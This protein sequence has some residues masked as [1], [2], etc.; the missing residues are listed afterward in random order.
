[1]DGRTGRT[2]IPGEVVAEG[3][4]DKMLEVV[5]GAPDPAAS[6]AFLLVVS[7]A[8]PGRLHV[9]DRPEVII[10]RSRYADIS[11]SERALSQQ[12]CKLVRHGEFHR[13][14]DLGSTNGTFVNNVRVQQAELKPGDSVRTGET[15]FTYMSG[16]ADAPAP[17]PNPGAPVH[18]QVHGQHPQ[19]QAQVHPQVHAPAVSAMPNLQGVPDAPS[20][21]ALAAYAPPGPQHPGYAPLARRG[22]PHGGEMIPAGYA[23]MPQVLA[24]PAATEE[25]ADLL[26]W[27]LKGIDF[28]RRYWL[29]IILL[30]LAGGALGGAS[31]KFKK[32]PARAE[33]ELSLIPMG[34]DNPV[35]GAR[36]MNFE[37]FRDAQNNF[38]RPALIHET[39]KEL[40]ETEISEQT[41]RGVV[42][43]LEF[44]KAGQFIYK[45]SFTSSTPEGAVKYL[46][47]HLR[48]YKE[49][50]IEK[51][52]RVLVVEATTLEE[53]LAETEEQLSAT[54]EALLAFKQENL[55]GLPEQ[56]SDLYR[57]L[58][59]L[60]TRKT[61]MSAEVAKAQNELALSRKQLK[62]E[63]PLIE[64]R[65]QESIPFATGIADLKK[66]IA[67][68][69]SEGKGEQHPMVGRAKEE[70]AALEALRD[71][72]IAHGTTKIVKSR[73]P[74]YKSYR[75]AVDE[76]ETNYE[77]TM[78]DLGAVTKDLVKTEELVQKLPRLQA[79]YSELV[80]SYDITEKTHA[81]LFSNLKS[82]RVRLEL[83]RAQAA[84]R[85]D[86]I[87]R[88]NVRPVS[89]I[90]TILI[91]SGMGLFGGLIFGIGLGVLRDLRRIVGA[92]LAARRT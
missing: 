90:F 26:T 58:I 73:N 60:G 11:I 69:R 80:R 79:E 13:L 3:G 35:E 18:P 74:V 91:R 36:R 53:Q 43:G 75:H 83:E 15:L 29:S 67:L 56:S 48:L 76:A 77:N 23:G 47:V 7:G 25:P 33:F 70:L 14:F 16:S 84:A 66:K 86:I 32:P 49:S 9:I 20:V 64:A 5:A 19:G 81:Q 78:A 27:I 92:R 41:L 65:I 46:D 51:A 6:H 88:P 1:M 37:F 8:D 40:G 61:A 62:S 34:A 39:L 82:V 45:G 21:T 31:Y 4:L 63:D 85:Y 2:V 10:G 30:T 57:Q 89:K 17:L 68:M 38:R 54:D 28:A 24:A 71:Q 44:Q 50:E 12:H 72:T 59:E 22:P 87:T 42:A 55:D 52:L